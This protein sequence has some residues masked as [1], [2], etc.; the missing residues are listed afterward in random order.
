MLDIKVSGAFLTHFIEFTLWKGSDNSPPIWGWGFGPFAE[1][2]LRAFHRAKMNSEDT[3][4]KYNKL[5]F[6]SKNQIE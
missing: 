6:S 3:Q 2:C 1:N 5:H 4:H